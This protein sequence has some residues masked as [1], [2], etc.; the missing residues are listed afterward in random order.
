MHQ[1][2]PDDANAHVFGDC[3]PLCVRL[4]GSEVQ[5]V[6]RTRQGVRGGRERRAVVVVVVVV[7]VIKYQRACVRVGG[8]HVEE[9]S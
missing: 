4:R 5:R 1:Q 6:L 3:E 9:G 2:T 7:H 8:V